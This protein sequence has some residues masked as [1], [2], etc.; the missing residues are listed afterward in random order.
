MNYSDQILH[1]Q[2]NAG[3]KTKA[4]TLNE[5]WPI[6]IGSSDYFQNAE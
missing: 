5:N 4:D 1:L 6:P 2:E 3:T